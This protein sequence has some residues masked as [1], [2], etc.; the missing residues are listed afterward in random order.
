[1]MGSRVRAERKTAPLPAPARLAS[2][3]EAAGA[4][5]RAVSPTVSQVDVAQVAYELFERRGCVSGHDV[6]DW[7]EAERIV[8][9]RRR[10]A[11]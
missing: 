2:Q 6:E 11:P 4:Q 9:A 10:T 3:R 5:G 8:R 1:M 7:L